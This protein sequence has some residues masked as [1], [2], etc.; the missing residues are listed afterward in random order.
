[1]SKQPTIDGSSDPLNEEELKRVLA[2]MKTVPVRQ[3][4]RALPRAPQLPW[5]TT[6]HKLPRCPSPVTELYLR[7]S[8]I[9]KKKRE[10]KMAADL[11]FLPFSLQLEHLELCQEEC[12]KKFT[13]QLAKPNVDAHMVEAM[14]T[15]TYKHFAKHRAGL[16]LGVTGTREDPIYVS[17]FD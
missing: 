13:E 3:H 4:M 5:R 15:A 9:A 11:H 6:P 16:L 12:N 7:E 1:M 14:R 17:A 2:Y 8:L 10:G